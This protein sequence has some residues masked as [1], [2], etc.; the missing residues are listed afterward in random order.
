MIY[1][2]GSRITVLPRK[3]GIQ[4][5]SLELP[6]KEV[7]MYNKCCLVSLGLKNIAGLGLF[8]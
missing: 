6:V 2:L 1:V 8:N 7:V 5:F 3:I 4:A